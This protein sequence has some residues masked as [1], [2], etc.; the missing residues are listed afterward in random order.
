MTKTAWHEN[1]RQDGARSPRWVRKCL[2][3]ISQFVA[4]RLAPSSLIAGAT[5]GQ[6]CRLL[7][8]NRFRVDTGYW[9]RTF[10]SFACTGWNSLV[11]LWEKRIYESKL[12]NVAIPPPIFVL[13]FNRSGTT[14]LH[15]LLCVDQRFAFPT[16]FQTMFPNTFL[17][18]EKF[19]TRLLRLLLPRTRPQ[20]EVYFDVGTP[21]ED[22]FALCTA[23]WLSPY[24]WCI[25]P[26]D[27]KYEQ[28][29]TLLDA[30]EREQDTWRAALMLFLQKLTHRY[31]RTLVLKSPPHTARIELLLEMFP[32]ARFVHVHRDPYTVFASNRRSSQQVQGYLQYQVAAGTD[33]ED[34]IIHLY[35]QTYDAFFE[36]LPSIPTGHFCEVAFD[37]LQVDPVGEMRRIYSELKLP[38]FDVVETDL[39]RYVE[40]LRYYR[41]NRHAPLD[42]QTRERV[43]NS[44]KRCFDA[45]GYK[46]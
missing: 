39:R 40:S 30:T 14:H 7:R 8:Q 41:M 28:F 3:A 10:S 18:T 25:F 1:I 44:W 46:T 11:Y 43:A 31:G 37:K 22:E 9:L 2:D 29:L 6:W 21:Q 17:T 20:D 19:G 36:Q 5:F 4:L 45:W 35:R 27:G 38:T 33:V 24:T 32:Q 16:V 34:R 23:T 26:R 15:N 12:G 13:G 42:D